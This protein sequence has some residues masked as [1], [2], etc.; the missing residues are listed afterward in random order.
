MRPPAHAALVFGALGVAWALELSAFLHVGCY[1][2]DAAI[3]PALIV[4]VPLAMAALGAA[5]AAFS[6]YALAIV[7][8]AGM[9]CGATIGML[10]WPPDGLISGARDGFVFGA[11]ASPMIALLRA[12]MH[13]RARGGSAIDVANRWCAWGCAS[14]LAAV[15]AALTLP[16]WKSFPACAIEPGPNVAI[17]VAAAIAS[18]GCAAMLAMHAVRTKQK[19][20][21]LSEFVDVGVGDERTEALPHPPTSYR[22]P[23]M[24]FIWV[25]GD[26]EYARK[27]LRLRARA[28]AIWAAISV[29]ASIA[30]AVTNAS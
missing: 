27:T 15:A 14:A 5:L 29:C 20:D 7:P 23:N 21:A 8:L 9:L 22:P 10:W 1:A 12:V 17:G 6:A 28:G 24:P 11:A 13:P 4:V 26:V 19:L 16:K 3:E 25:R 2:H 30:A 18:V